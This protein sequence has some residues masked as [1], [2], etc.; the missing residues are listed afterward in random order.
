MSQTLSIRSILYDNAT[1][2]FLLPPFPSHILS[3]TPFI[4]FFFS[5]ALSNFSFVAVST[6]RPLSHALPPFPTRSLFLK[7]FLRLLNL[8]CVSHLIFLPLTPSISLLVN[9]CLPVF[10][11]IIH[12]FSLA[13]TQYFLFPYSSFPCYSSPIFNYKISFI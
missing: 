6:R 2:P 3:P 1:S 8:P 5:H 7:H 10:L 11:H 13:H 9:V 4:Y 12:T